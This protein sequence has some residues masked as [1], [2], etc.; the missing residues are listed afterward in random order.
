MPT[1]IEILWALSAGLLLLIANLGA[2]VIM[3][4]LTRKRNVLTVSARHLAGASGAILGTF[5]IA[6][7]DSDFVNDSSIIGVDYGS[8]VQLWLSLSTAVL[9]TTLSMAGLAERSTVMSNLI[10]GLVMGALLVPVAASARLPDG[11]LSSIAFGDRTFIDTAAASLFT[12][13]GVAALVG[14]IIIGPRR[15]RVGADGALRIISGKSMPV[16]MVGTLLMIPGL[17]GALGRPGDEWNQDVLDG[18]IRLAVGGAVGAVVGIVIGAFLSGRI[19]LGPVLHA[20]LA[21]VVTATGDP[22]GM[23]TFSLAFYAASGA[24]LALT[25]NRYL[26]RIN[27]DDPVGIVATFGVAGV[28]GSLSVGLM[29]TEQFL[30]QVLGVGLVVAMTFIVTGVVFALLRIFRLLR[31]NSDIEVAGLEL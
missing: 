23:T 27:I 19:S 15:G 9:M 25:V 18:A 7:V 29:D 26:E 30:A 13:A 17:I 2:V 31:I 14:T 10:V 6:N 28:W 24:I 20:T 4:G 11:F 21:G 5:A 3:E 22:Q 1:D 16:A 8:N 12:V